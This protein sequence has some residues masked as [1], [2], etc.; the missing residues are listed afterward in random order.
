MKKNE[1]R[2]W[3]RNLIKLRFGQMMMMGRMKGGEKV[4]DQKERKGKNVAKTKIPST[5]SN[6]SIKERKKEKKRKE[7][8]RKKMVTDGKSFLSI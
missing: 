4:F 7:K 3:G 8:R 2:E 1:T 5:K 6:V